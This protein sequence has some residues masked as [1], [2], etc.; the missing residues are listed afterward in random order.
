M[1]SK[2]ALYVNA[3]ARHESADF[4]GAAHM[5]ELM[6]Y[7]STAHLSYLRQMK[8]AEAVSGHLDVDASRFVF[9]LNQINFI[10]M[11]IIIFFQI[12]FLYIALQINNKMLNNINNDAILIFQ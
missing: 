3:G 12:L 7:R 5:T 2:V 10:F 6:A 1:T 8:V 4:A 9:Y 11:Y